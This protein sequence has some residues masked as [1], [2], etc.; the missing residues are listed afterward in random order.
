M[1]AELAVTVEMEGPLA[2]LT[3]QHAPH[4]LL[5]PVLM[6]A[7]LGGFKEAED[8]GARAVL[9]KSGLR[10]FSAGA[11]PALLGQ[12][13]QSGALAVSP[14]KF[15]SDLEAFPL[16][17]VAAVHGVCVG[18]GL[19]LAM[20]C[21]FIIAARSSKL[22]AVEA[23]LGINP[24]MG[25]IQRQVER[26]GIARAK[27]MSMLARRYDA[28]TLE[29]WNI[30]NRVVDDE[31]LEEASKALALEI[32]NGPTMAHKITKQLANLAADKGVKAADDV[33]ED[34][35]K[36]LWVSEDLK[37]GFESMM[38]QGPGLA[39]FKGK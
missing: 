7:V 29:K 26:A 18:G 8:A 34:M 24:L 6:D 27:E 12:A 1:S 23:S 10:H 35:Q 13:M 14:A 9:M 37:I 30:I 5:G 2:I 31:K 36:P 20:A 16:P 39:V 28:E 4:N 33:M 21:D 25:G 22:G 11:D 17:V 19:E 3:L 32:A 15:L 38:A